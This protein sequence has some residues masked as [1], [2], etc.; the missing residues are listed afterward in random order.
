VRI[1]EGKRREEGKGRSATRAA[2]APNLDPVVMRIVCLLAASPVT[3][4]RVALANGASAQDD[5]VGV[6]G[7][8]SF[9]LVQQSGK[10]D[11]KNRS[12]SGSAPALTFPRS[13]PEVEPLLL[14]GKLQL[15]ENNASPLPL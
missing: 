6:G 3:R 7:P 2:T 8:V 14:K 15:E 4:D 13:E 9:E 5:L 11:E 10:W 12:S 1:R